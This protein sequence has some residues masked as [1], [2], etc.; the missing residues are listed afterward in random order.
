[1]INDHPK[2][3][4]RALVYTQDEAE[5]RCVR[6][7]LG[8]NGIESRIERFPEQTGDYWCHV[9]VKRKEAPRADAFVIGFVAGRAMSGDLM[10]GRPIPEVEAWEMEHVEAL[11]GPPDVWCTSYCNHGHHM[12]TGKPI[13]HRCYV[14]PPAALRFER[15]GRTDEAIEAI[16]MAQPLREHAGAR[17]P[18]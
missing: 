14:L 5:C 11:E 3:P 17:A 18:Q 9:S 8:R 2:D 1:M 16:R 6:Y 4:R 13:G 15:E 12:R 10:Y 7:L